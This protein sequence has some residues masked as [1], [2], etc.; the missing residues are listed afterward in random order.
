MLNFGKESENKSREKA[1]KEY[2][3]TVIN[4]D[5]SDFRKAVIPMHEALAKRDSKSK[6]LIDYIKNYGL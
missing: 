2:N 4:P 6:E 5:I 1:I 3:V